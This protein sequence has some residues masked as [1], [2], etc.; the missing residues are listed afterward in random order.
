MTWGKKTGDF[1]LK[2][3]YECYNRQELEDELTK[4]KFSPGMKL[5]QTG[6]GRVAKGAQ[7]II[8][9]AGFKQVDSA[10]FLNE[11]FDEPVYT[12]LSLKDYYRPK[13]GGAFEMSHFI[14][15]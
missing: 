1:D 3:A 6:R 9:H 13:D 14:D 4:V 5:V 11:D 12:Q 7:E 8:E 15:N 2:P 10:A